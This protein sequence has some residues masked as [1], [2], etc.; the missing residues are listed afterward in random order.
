MQC[1]LL[2]SFQKFLKKESVNKLAET[3]EDNEIS[4]EQWNQFF[5]KFENLMC[6]EGEEDSD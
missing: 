1:K 4:Q 5:S 3:P 2:A 6:E